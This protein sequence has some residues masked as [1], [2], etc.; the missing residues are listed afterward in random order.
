MPKPNNY[1]LANLR[2]GTDDVKCMLFMSWSTHMYCSPLS[3]LNST[4]SSIK[5]YI[6]R[7][8]DVLC[9][10]KPC[11]AVPCRAMPCHAVPCRAMPFHAVPCR[12]MPCHVVPCR[13]MPCHAVPCRAM[14]CHAVP[15]RAMP[16]H[17]V[18]CRAM[19]CHA[20][21]CRAMP[22]YAVPCSLILILSQGNATELFVKH[23]I[24][25]LFKIL[26]NVLITSGGA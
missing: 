24:P 15:C 7:C 16:C 14:P 25:S 8:N 4:S 6:V 9:R 2:Y 17:A 3:W 21:P 12:A 5:K 1:D 20:V 23:V 19:P 13:A 26:S 11:H 10:A 22:C 18:P